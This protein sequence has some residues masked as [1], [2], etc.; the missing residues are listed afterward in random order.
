MTFLN[1]DLRAYRTACHAKGSAMRLTFKTF[2]RIIW[3]SISGIAA[4]AFHGVG[5]LFSFLFFT[6]IITRPT[7]ETP[8]TKRA[9][10]RIQT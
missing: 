8:S 6:R 10:T 4:E 9:I 3:T 5:R 1:Q 7:Q 2:V